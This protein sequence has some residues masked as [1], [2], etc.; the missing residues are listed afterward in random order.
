MGGGNKCLLRARELGS[1]KQFECAHPS[2]NRTEELVELPRKL[3]RSLE[4]F[5]DGEDCHLERQHV[6]TLHSNGVS[7]VDVPREPVDQDTSLGRCHFGGH[8]KHYGSAQN[9]HDS[10]PCWGLNIDAF[11]F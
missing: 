10:P 6:E 8:V 9:L 2:S 3:G 5:E 11:C 7:D 4:V 1:A